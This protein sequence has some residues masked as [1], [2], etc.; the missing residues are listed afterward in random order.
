[1]LQILRHYV[2]KENKQYTLNQIDKIQHIIQLKRRDESGILFLDGE[3]KQIELI[4][5]PKKPRS[6]TI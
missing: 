2:K 3:N 6:D 4:T 5:Q 1:M